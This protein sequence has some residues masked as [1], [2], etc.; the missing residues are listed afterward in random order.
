MTDKLTGGPAPESNSVRQ[1]PSG[2]HLT[3]EGAKA[4]FTGTQR[5]QYPKGSEPKPEPG[6][7]A[8]GPTGDSQNGSFGT[9]KPAAPIATRK[10][11]ERSNT[12]SRSNP[13]SVSK[14]TNHPL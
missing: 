5:G 2:D 13:W 14:S 12:G 10:G 6:S 7:I 4:N 11:G 8:Q 1:G 9:G 3:P